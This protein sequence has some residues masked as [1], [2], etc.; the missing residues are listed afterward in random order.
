M[1]IDIIAR[2]LAA[3]LVDKNGKIANDKLPTLDVNG[4]SGFFPIGKLTSIED[5]QGKT[6]EEVLLTMFFGITNPTFT[7]PTLQ[8][9]CDESNKVLIAG[10]ENIISGNLVFNRGTINPA[11]GTSGYRAGAATEYKINNQILES[12]AFS[13]S[14]IPNYGENS[15]TATVSYAQ[16]EQPLN[17]VGENYDSPYPAGQISAVLDLQAVYPIYN[18]QQ[19]ELDFDWFADDSGEAYKIVVPSEQQTGL[20]QSFAINNNIS[21]IGIKQYNIMSQQWEWIGG[22]AQ[23]SITTFD[24]SLINIDN[25]NYKCYT[26]N[27]AD[28]AARELLIFVQGVN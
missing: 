8:I 16:G 21:L 3:S 14:L 4:L 20:K 24:E 9:V 22:T 15:I 28:T 5:L 27:D 18:G 26:N 11:Y 10:K 7:N 25:V 17:S 1:A 6:A 2:G 12:N 19:E 23:A 13:I